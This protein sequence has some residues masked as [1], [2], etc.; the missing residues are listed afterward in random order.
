MDRFITLA[1]ALL[2]ASNDTV[3]LVSAGHPPPLVYRQTSGQVEVASAEE[4][5]GLPL[6]VMPS[7]SYRSH[8]LQL[9]PGDS[10]LL[11][12]DGITDAVD[13]QNQ[14]I[15]QK[16]IQTAIQDRETTPRQLGERVIKTIRQQ[17]AAAR[18]PHD[19]MTLVCFGRTVAG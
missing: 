9:E 1:A 8:Q 5:I 18:R 12:S 14:P 2:D 4:A 11:F 6:G 16:A 15:H 10:V 3:T 7:F 13:K 17:A 19:D